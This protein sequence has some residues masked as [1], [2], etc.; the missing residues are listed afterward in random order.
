[1]FSFSMQDKEVN[2]ITAV[3]L[4]ALSKVSED[5]GNETTNKYR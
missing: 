1:M 3:Y 4:A 2:V 5:I